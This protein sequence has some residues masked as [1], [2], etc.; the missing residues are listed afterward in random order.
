M[1]SVGRSRLAPFHRGVARG[2]EYYT[3]TASF[4]L[5]RQLLA[6]CMALIIAH[7]FGLSSR[8]TERREELLDIV[9][10]QCR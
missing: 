2:L 1:G 6:I 9:G 10:G 3:S 4:L 5:H 7:K 8:R